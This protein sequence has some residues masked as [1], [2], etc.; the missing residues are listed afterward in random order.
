MAKV[1]GNRISSEGGDVVEDSCLTP[2]YAV[3]WIR[4][5]RIAEAGITSGTGPKL[6]HTGR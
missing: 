6:L 3:D 5:D 1:D 4:I 2:N